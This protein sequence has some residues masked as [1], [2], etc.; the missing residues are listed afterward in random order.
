[1]A[2][3]DEIMTCD[4]GTLAFI[5]PTG[6]GTILSSIPIPDSVFVSEYN[7]VSSLISGVNLYTLAQSTPFKLQ[8]IKNVKLVL[9]E[10]KK[11]DQWVGVV[12]GVFNEIT[13]NQAVL[14]FE[15]PLYVLTDL[16]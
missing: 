10:N 6:E 2:A 12:V 15:L 1:M 11:H 9:F 7:W 14:N 16:N 4:V 3:G 5:D 8:V 13:V